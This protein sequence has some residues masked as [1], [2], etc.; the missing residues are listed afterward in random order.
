MSGPLSDDVARAGAKVRLARLPVCG[1][2]VFALGS[3][4]SHGRVT[5]TLAARCR[6]K[7]DRCDNGNQ[8][9]SKRCKRGFCYPRR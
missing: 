4:L 2:L 1:L 6:K 9:C 5:R 7:S 3:V 8:C